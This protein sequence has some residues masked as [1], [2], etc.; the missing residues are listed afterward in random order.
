MYVIPVKAGIVSGRSRMAR[1]RER[2][3]NTAFRRAGRNIERPW[4][5]AICFFCGAFRKAYSIR[6]GGSAAAVSGRTKAER[7]KRVCEIK[8]IY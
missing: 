6:S 3:N 5:R 8:E 2:Q 7:V 1:V 4:L